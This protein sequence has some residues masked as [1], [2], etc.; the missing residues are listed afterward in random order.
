MIS[1][2]DREPPTYCEVLRG[3]TDQT[4]RLPCRAGAWPGELA[5]GPW[6][7]ARV[8]PSLTRSCS[9]A[10]HWWE[11]VPH[12]VSPG[13]GQSLIARV[14]TGGPTPWRVPSGKLDVS[15]TVWRP[16]Y[17]GCSLNSLSYTCHLHCWSHPTAASGPS[18][19]DTVRERKLVV[20]NEW[21]FNATWRRW[22]GQ[23]LSYEIKC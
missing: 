15:Y 20:V 23:I 14:A 22:K 21:P 17:H 11:R 6:R 4:L 13:S 18:V 2:E 12:E 3:Q 8:G 19:V 9:G 10:P 5:G 1:C 16:S 7:V